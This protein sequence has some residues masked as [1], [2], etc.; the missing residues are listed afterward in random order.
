MIRQP[1]TRNKIATLV[2]TLAH[3][4]SSTPIYTLASSCHRSEGD[5]GAERTAGGG[6]GHRRSPTR[7][8]ALVAEAARGSVEQLPARARELHAELELAPPV[9]ALS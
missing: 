7:R 6:G 1:Q 3:L 2:Q 4:S 5:A 9:A 8:S